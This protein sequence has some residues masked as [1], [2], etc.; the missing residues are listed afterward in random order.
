MGAARGDRRN[1][2]AVWGHHFAGDPRALFHADEDCGK[3][4]LCVRLCPAHAAA[5]RLILWELSIPEALAGDLPQKAVHHPGY[6][7]RHW[8]G[9]RK[10]PAA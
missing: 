2:E 1:C 6:P 8:R 3:G 10:R 5:E 7:R 9:G 4:L